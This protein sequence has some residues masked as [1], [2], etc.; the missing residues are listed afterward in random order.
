M[1]YLVH[2]LDMDLSYIGQYIAANTVIGIQ[3]V[4]KLQVKTKFLKFFPKISNCIL[5]IKVLHF[6]KTFDFDSIFGINKVDFVFKILITDH[7]LDF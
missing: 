5:L 6:S 1:K 7:K 3:C 4:K 2:F